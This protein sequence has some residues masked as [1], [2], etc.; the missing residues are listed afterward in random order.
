MVN[1]NGYT[2]L[3]WAMDAE[4]S[5][6][7]RYLAEVTHAGLFISL[8]MLARS[9]LVISPSI[10][11]FVVRCREEK[12]TIL[13]GMKE[14]AAYGNT[15]LLKQLLV[16]SNMNIAKDILDDLVQLAIMAESPATCEAVMGVCDE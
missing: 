11:S 13:A 12:D 5:E 16:G 15:A 3:S 4:D 14:A 2:A 8:Q 7:V 6:T 9:Q 1:I 10:K